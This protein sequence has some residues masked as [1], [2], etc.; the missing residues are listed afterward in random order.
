[1]HSFM[2]PQGQNL[3]KPQCPI[4]HVISGNNINRVRTHFAPPGLC[5]DQICQDSVDRVFAAVIGLPLVGLAVAIGL[6]LRTPPYVGEDPKFFE[7]PNTGAIFESEDGRR[8]DRDNRGE[9]IFKAIGFTPWPVPAEE[10][11]HSE[12]LRLM[13]GPVKKRVP[14]T[15][16][17]DKILPQPSMLVVVTLPRPLGIVFEEDL[18]SRNQPCIRVAELLERGNAEQLFKTAKLD[19]SLAQYA[20]MPGDVLRAV[21]CTNI[22]YKT[23]A[24]LFG[25]QLPMREVVVY[26]ADGETWPKT[27]A[28]LQEGLVSDGE[29]QV[30]LERKVSTLFF[31]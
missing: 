1:M 5:F 2:F 12:G 31:S 7:D 17:F 21:T 19:V 29:V 15:Y 14:R 18:S 13:V 30:V 16:V 4:S 25:A 27:A 11:A 9:L 28:A 10:A 22:V 24:L 26:G 20:A 8:P 6:A 3:R 23:G